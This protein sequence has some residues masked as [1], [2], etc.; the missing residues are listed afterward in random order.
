MTLLGSSEG[1]NRKPDASNLLRGG[2]RG[3]VRHTAQRDRS[4][5]HDGND[6][7]LYLELPQTTKS[8]SKKKSDNRL[9]GKEKR[10]RWIGKQDVHFA[11]TSSVYPTS[12]HRRKSRRNRSKERRESLPS[13]RRSRGE[14]NHVAQLF[15]GEEKVE[16][17]REPGR[18]D[19]SSIEER[20]LR[21]GD[22]PVHR[23]D[24]ENF[25]ADAAGL[26]DCR[27]EKYQRAKSAPSS[28]RIRLVNQFEGRERK[29]A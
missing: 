8:C 11:Q 26:D 13:E 27:L 18:Q 7:K 5:A 24:W 28:E 17:E 23:E 29:S 14:K 10:G 15:S 25:G 6:K 1:A 20:R 2:G 19:G 16:S 22:R 12:K 4:Q 21:T 3:T 9:G